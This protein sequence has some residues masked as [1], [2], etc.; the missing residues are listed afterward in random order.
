MGCCKDSAKDTLLPFVPS[1]SAVKQ[2]PLHHHILTFLTGDEQDVT[3]LVAVPDARPAQRPRT[4]EASHINQDANRTFAVAP[5]LDQADEMEYKVLAH[6]LLSKKGVGSGYELGR[7]KGYQMYGSTNRALGRNCAH[8]SER[9]LNNNFYVTFERSGN[10]MYHCFG[11]SCSAKPPLLLGQWTHTLRSLLDS[12]DMWVPG[13]KVDAALLRNLQKAAIRAT[14][15]KEK[16]TNQPWYDELEQVICRYLS[17]FF[18]F[19]SKPSVYVVQTL[20]QDGSVATYTRYDSTRLKNVVMPYQ[21]AFDIWNKSHFRETLATKIKF[22]GQPWSDRVG[23]EEY[24]LCEGMMPLLKEPHRPIT[25]AD[26][27]EMKPILDHIHDSI[28]AGSDEDY[29]NL[30]AWLA[31]VVQDPAQ[32]VGWCPVRIVCMTSKP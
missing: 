24:N 20:E 15:A 28:C 10:I 8:G 26:M 3:D 2:H 4:T 29:A 31:H 22:V 32:K 9:H 16:L 25:E 27:A 11:A 12:P 30:M 1:P 21:F 5:W 7:L 23:P 14:P 19:V 13:S 18:I 17:H 6:T